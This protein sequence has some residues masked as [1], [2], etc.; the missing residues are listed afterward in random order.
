M[1]QVPQPFNWRLTLLAVWLAGAGLLIARI[2]IA[3][4]V[5]ARR[6]RRA[7]GAGADAI[8]LLDDCRARWACGRTCA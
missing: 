4:V 8:A 6:L 3:H 1:A 2:M 7:P 5:L